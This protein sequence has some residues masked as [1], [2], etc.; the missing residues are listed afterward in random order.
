M[1]IFALVTDDGPHPPEKWARVTANLIMGNVGR[2]SKSVTLHDA[3]AFEEKL[4]ALL[5]NHHGRAQRH[6]RAAIE[7]EGTER[8][9]GSIDTSGHIPDAVDDIIALAKGTSLDEYFSRSEE[10]VVNDDGTTTTVLSTRDFLERLLHQHF[11]NVMHI[12][13]SWH[14]DSVPDHPQ[15]KA[16]RD[17]SLGPPPASVEE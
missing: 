12:E 1:E 8:L 2:R 10:V 6:E 3:Q 16:F 11:H 7:T 17:A 15:A 5:T 4:L 9:A 14:A 13:R